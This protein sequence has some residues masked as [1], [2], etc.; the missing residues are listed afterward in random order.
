[1]I[2]NN[3]K[4]TVA[5]FIVLIALGAGIR[6]YQLGN[7]PGGLNQDE[8]ASAYDAYA[9]LHYG[10]DRTGA[11][12]PVH[13]SNFGPGQSALLAYLTIPF[14]AVLDLNIFSIRLFP[15]LFCIVCLVGIFFL[16]RRIAGNRLAYFAL[17]LLAICPWH[18]MVSRWAHENFLLTGTVLFAIL[19]LVRAQSNKR[20]LVWSFVVLAL[21]LY[22]YSPAVAFVPLFLMT[23]GIYAIWHRIFAIKEWILSIVVFAILSMP[24]FLFI[25]VNHFGLQSMDFGFLTIPKLASDLNYH[26][27]ATVLGGASWFESIK[28]VIEILFIDGADDLAW[29]S[30]PN[31][32]I[33]YVVSIPLFFFG[34]FCLARDFWKDKA[35]SLLA[36]ILLWFLVSFFVVTL[37]SPNINRMNLVFIPMIFLS[38]YGLNSIWKFSKSFALLFLLLFAISFFHFTYNYFGDDYTSKIGDQFFESYTDAIEYAVEH[39]APEDTLYMTD[40]VNQSYIYVLFAI[41]ANVH[42]YIQ[43]V[44]IA[45]KSAIFHSVRSFDRFKFGLNS[46]AWNKGKVLVIRNNERQNIDSNKYIIKRFKNYTVLF[47]KDTALP[48][49]E[50]IY[51]INDSLFLSLPKIYDQPLSVM[52]YDFYGTDSIQV[53][54]TQKSDSLSIAVSQL[55]EGLNRLRVGNATTFVFLETDRKKLVDVAKLKG[56]QDFGTIQRNHSYEGRSLSAGSIDIP[57][58]FG[59]HADSRYVLNS[60]K[61]V[62]SLSVIIGIANSS[63]DCGDG[64]VFKIYGNTDMLYS[65]RLS[66]GAASKI[67]LSVIGADSIAFVT[68]KGENTHCD[69][70]NWIAP[71]LSKY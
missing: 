34:L 36:P 24:M 61:Q 64:A 71:M 27:G 45:N 70:T 33:L 2:Q 30:L 38:S 5:I 62:D 49:D 68:E 65:S 20:G 52:S 58:G 7:I 56:S 11:H 22:T 26:K 67:A 41:R 4:W 17:F 37:A 55:F 59:T 40:N 63:G 69:H 46:Q 12:N 39:A 53:D 29:N 1:M 32:H 66:H 28:R 21:S 18:I 60:A 19:L 57:W 14:I 15:A 8:A 54:Y 43:T 13:L 50:R 3:R 25:L 6:L 42:D 47:R 23:Y 48:Q 16:A 51:H 44:D 9:I 10:V 31:V 35:P